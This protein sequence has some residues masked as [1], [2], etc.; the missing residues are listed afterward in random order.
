MGKNVLR[1]SEDQIWAHLVEKLSKVMFEMLHIQVW[2]NKP[3]GPCEIHLELTDLLCSAALFQEA[4]T[5]SLEVSFC[6]DAD[7]LSSAAINVT[8]DPME[9][10]CSVWSSLFL[11]KRSLVEFDVNKW[12]KATEQAC[13]HDHNHYSFLLLELTHCCS[14]EDVESNRFIQE[15]TK[16]RLNFARINFSNRISL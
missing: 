15:N 3:G 7:E 2:E 9:R 4:S 8:E 11:L 12:H 14:L 5:L 13:T 16:A 6:T 10:S 1:W